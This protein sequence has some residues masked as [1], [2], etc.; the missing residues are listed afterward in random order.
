[1]LNH[2]EQRIKNYRPHQLW[3]KRWVHR[4]AVAAVVAHRPE[5]GEPAV[6]LMQ[7]ATREGDPWSG[8]MSFPGGR[9]DAQDK[10]SLDTAIRETQE[11]LGL[12]L[13][14]Q[15][16]YWGQL[17]DIMARPV[18]WRRLPMVVTPFV[19]ALT[20]EPTWQLDPREVADTIWVPLSFLANPSNRGQMT[21]QRGKISLKLPCYD[22]QN[23]RIWGLTLRML[24]ELMPLLLPH[25]NQ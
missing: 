6:L 13:H 8:H 23:K 21:W 3:W 9:A 19:F 22:Y 14:Q 5:L 18:S 1:M 7:R 2:L 10:Q 4:S 15:G 24:D 25:P 20:H 12:N 11:E 16:Q 17:S